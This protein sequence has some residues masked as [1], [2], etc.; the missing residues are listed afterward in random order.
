MTNKTNIRDIISGLYL[1]DID[2]F[3]VTLLEAVNFKNPYAINKA[4][5]QVGA[6]DTL[7]QYSLGFDTDYSFLKL[8]KETKKRVLAFAETYNKI[9]PN[10]RLDGMKIDRAIKRNDASAIEK[11]Y[12]KSLNEFVSNS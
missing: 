1:A 11:E 12:S 4:F 6:L 8:D 10:I 5:S 7:K 2:R 3:S 9:S